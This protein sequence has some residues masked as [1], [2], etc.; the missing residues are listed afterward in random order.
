MQF[1]VTMESPLNK[2]KRQ[3]VSFMVTGDTLEEAMEGLVV[4]V[5]SMKRRV[6]PRVHVKKQLMKLFI[7]KDRMEATYPETP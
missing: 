6:H 4:R 5:Y 1:S 2:T 3:Q 7:L